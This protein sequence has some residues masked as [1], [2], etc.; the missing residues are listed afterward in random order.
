MREDY[1]IR[2]GGLSHMQNIVVW[3]LVPSDKNIVAEKIPRYN[4]LY[5]SPFLELIFR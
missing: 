1:F 2:G 4:I 3:F 5:P